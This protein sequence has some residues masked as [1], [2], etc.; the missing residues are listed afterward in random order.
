ML[1][2]GYTVTTEI[3][4]MALTS[5]QKQA[6]FRA[7]KKEVGSERLQVVVNLH[8]R[9]ALQRLSRHFGL[10]QSAMLERLL[11]N[12]QSRVTH[13]LSDDAYKQY[14]GEPVTG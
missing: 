13:D 5:A 11:L 4:E 1:S 10:S 2:H 7:R 6:A 12:E 3:D 8:A 14:L 9:L